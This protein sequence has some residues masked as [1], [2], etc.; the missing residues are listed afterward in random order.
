MS[1]SHKQTTFYVNK[2][3]LLEQRTAS[4]RLRYQQLR[5]QFHYLT[6]C[7]SLVVEVRSGKTGRKLIQ[8]ISNVQEKNFNDKGRGVFVGK[9]QYLTDTKRVPTTDVL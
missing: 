5:S 4:K 6:S 8:S 2:V 3:I 7:N 1:F 9:L